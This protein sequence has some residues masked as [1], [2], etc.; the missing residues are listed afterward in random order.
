MILCVSTL[1]SICPMG[2][3]SGA[4][5][6]FSFYLDGGIVKQETLKGKV[7]WSEYKRDIGDFK[8]DKVD[9]NLKTENSQVS[10]KIISKPEES[11]MYTSNH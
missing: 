6:E 7:V 8:Y 1:S 2:G 9:V 4:E 11:W 3:Y 10:W 5:A